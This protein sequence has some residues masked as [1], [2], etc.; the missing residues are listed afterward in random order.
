MFLLFVYYGHD[1]GTQ[2]IKSVET[3][4]ESSFQ[5]LKK[6]FKAFKSKLNAKCFIKIKNN[7]HTFHD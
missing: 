4:L 1:L 2:V 6:R 7:S 3:N 5:F